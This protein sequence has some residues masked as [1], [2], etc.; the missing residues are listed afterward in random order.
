M[1]SEGHDEAFIVTF[2]LPQVLE[3][4]LPLL[5][6]DVGIDKAVSATLHEQH[7]REVVKLKEGEGGVCVSCLVCGDETGLP[8]APARHLPLT[9]QLTGISTSPVVSPRFTGVIHVL[10]CFW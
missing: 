1:D 6:N 9:S 10:A 5:L 7:G 3:P 2:I 8:P 4:V